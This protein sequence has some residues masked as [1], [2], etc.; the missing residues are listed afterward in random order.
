VTFGVE[1]EDED[2]LLDAIVALDDVFRSGGLPEAAYR[3][4][5]TELKDRLKAI[6]NQL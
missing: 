6:K 5:R 4:R 3:Q 2:T 1:N